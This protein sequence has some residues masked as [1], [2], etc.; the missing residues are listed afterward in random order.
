MSLGLKAST[1]CCSLSVR[2]CDVSVGSWPEVC[3]IF[4]WSWIIPKSRPIASLDHS[5]IARARVVVP[6]VL[7]AD[8]YQFHVPLPPA[9]LRPLPRGLNLA[10][11]AVGVRAV[12]AV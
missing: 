12:L 8:K 1:C 11:L 5:L 6:G 3:G 10:C 7:A 4:Q 2:K 9:S